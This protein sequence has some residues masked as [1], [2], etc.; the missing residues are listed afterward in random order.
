MLGK[1]VF[2]L[3]PI[4]KNNNVHIR[5]W[6]QFWNFIKKVGG[7]IVFEI[8]RFPKSFLNMI[9]YT[10]AKRHTSVTKTAY[11]VLFWHTPVSLPERLV[12]VQG[13]KRPFPSSTASITITSRNK[14]KYR[15]NIINVGLCCQI[16]GTW[17]NNFC[18]KTLILLYVSEL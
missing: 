5:L 9:S 17:V 14:H 13:V 18:L 7:H 2:E 4:E 1:R 15:Q 11:R 10:C 8:E 16:S 12:T 6:R 3:S